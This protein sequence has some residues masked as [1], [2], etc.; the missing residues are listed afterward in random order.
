MAGCSQLLTLNI[1]IESQLIDLGALSGFNASGRREL[2]C[3]DFQRRTHLFVDSILRIAEQGNEV[4]VVCADER[5][6]GIFQ[7]IEIEAAV[8]LCWPYWG[9]RD[10]A[11]VFEERG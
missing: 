3:G 2:G 9:G 10:G 8:R 1:D 6:M 4:G 5:G 7:H 11:G